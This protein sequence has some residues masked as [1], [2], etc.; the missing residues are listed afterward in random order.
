VVTIG[1]EEYKV[2]PGDAVIF[3]PN[4]PHALKNVGKTSLWLIAINVPPK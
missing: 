2:K 3:P 1:K 4:M